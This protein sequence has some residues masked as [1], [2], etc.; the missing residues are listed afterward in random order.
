MFFFPPKGITFGENYPHRII[1]D[2]EDRREQSLKDV[3]EVRMEHPEYTDE[4][5]GSDMVPVPDHLLALT[6]GQTAEEGDVIKSQTGRFLLP[7]ITRKEFKYKTLQPDSKDNPYN[8][9]LKGYVSRKRD[10]TIAYMNE[11]HFTAS[12]I[13]E[14]AQLHER[15]ERTARIMEGLPEPHN[16][17]TTNR[18]TPRSDPFS[19]IPPAYFHL[20]N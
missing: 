1:V 9:V 3:V 19:I 5:S 16:P 11:R 15:K 20:A 14:G 8:T 4:V 10:E 13:H 7:V 12:T 2:L 6:L 17:K 18:R